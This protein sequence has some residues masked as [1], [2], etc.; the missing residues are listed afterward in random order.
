MTVDPMIE[1]LVSGVLDIRHMAA[2]WDELVRLAVSIRAGTT[3]AS[4][5]LRRLAAY[6][7]QNGLAVALRDVGRLERTVFTLD[8]ILSRDMRRR[9]QLG[10]NKGEA[11]NALARASSSTGLANCV[12]DNLKVRPLEHQG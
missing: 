10:L 2:N 12:I 4:A 3:S 11:R 1:P 6:P 5:V 8:W 9:T 7:L